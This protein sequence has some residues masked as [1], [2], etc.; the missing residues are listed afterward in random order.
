MN[1]LLGSFRRKQV[2]RRGFWVRGGA[3]DGWRAF[4]GLRIA[5]GIGADWL[6]NRTLLRGLRRKKDLGG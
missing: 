2:L 1:E 4:I 3:D 6:K 5:F